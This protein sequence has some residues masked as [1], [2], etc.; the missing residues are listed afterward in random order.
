MNLFGGDFI[1]SSNRISNLHSKFSINLVVDV[2]IPYE[3][4]I[5]F[6]KLCMLLWLNAQTIYLNNRKNFER[7]IVNTLMQL[8]Y[9]V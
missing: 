5:H 8:K 3:S 6:T 1:T 4:Q 2:E 7:E 9:I